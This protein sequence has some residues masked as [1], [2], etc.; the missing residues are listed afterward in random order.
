MKKPVLFIDEFAKVEQILFLRS[1]AY[2]AQIPC[3][4]ASTNAKISNMISFSNPTS[5]A[6]RTPWCN[7]ITCLPPCVFEGIISI[8]KVGDN[9]V[10]L[11]SCFDLQALSGERSESNSGNLVL[12][13][14]RLLLNC[15]I[16]HSS[17]GFKNQIRYI[18]KFIRE[19]SK[20]C[21]QGIAYIAVEKLLDVLKTYREGMDVWAE[22]I[23]LISKRI[24]ERKVNL[25]SR[26]SLFFSL[27]SFSLSLPVTFVDSNKR[28]SEGL[29][30]YSVNENLYYFGERPDGQAAD[31]YNPI[32]PLNRI[33]RK[34]KYVF[35]DRDYEFKSYLP[36]FDVD[37]LTHM[38]LWNLIRLVG[39]E[40]NITVAKV[41][42]QDYQRK[43]Y[44]FNVRSISR[45][46]NY[47]EQL[48]LFAA[49]NASQQSFNGSVNG[50]L[51]LKEFAIQCQ[52]IS[53]KTII[54]S[55]SL[56]Q[57]LITDIP[58]SL[59]SFLASISLPYYV[60]QTYS[61]PY[62]DPLVR[63]GICQRN[64]NSDGVD[65]TFQIND[66]ESGYIECKNLN[67]KVTRSLAMKY[68]IRAMKK[69]SPITILLVNKASRSLRS[70]VKFN[71]FFE[72]SVS[73]ETTSSII[74][75]KFENEVFSLETSHADT[76]ASKSKKRAPKKSKLEKSKRVTYSFSEEISKKRI[77]DSSIPLDF[78]VNIYALVHIPTSSGTLRLDFITLHE[79]VDPN[80]VFIVL[81]S[82]TNFSPESPVDKS[83]D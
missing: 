65:L 40:K 11:V 19:Q 80:G 3:I 56:L 21:L 69:R 14:D 64:E 52:I 55:G 13:V 58:E 1:L 83:S 47:Q 51:F 7:V 48:A 71:E 39:P 82:N 15:N 76:Q 42:Q 17:E 36:N 34:L 28:Y 62:L 45:D 63:I 23:K 46:H 37:I 4:L 25:K 6:E 18:F 41:I 26:V 72:P 78:G 10:P 59:Q 81:E 57:D 60:P 5:S 8:L 31:Q 29:A 33:G 49:A 74:Q 66:R 79:A 75:P 68:I 27:C 35:A 32:T 22:L 30:S 73:L 77:L 67:A 16:P 9:N 53:K 24:Q 61:I 12:N 70:Q 43:H 20:S 54:S 38:A 50:V 44:P 2:C